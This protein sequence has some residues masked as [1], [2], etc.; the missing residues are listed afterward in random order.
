MC[1]LS[2]GVKQCYPTLSPQGG[3]IGT[4][5]CGEPAQKPALSTPCTW[6]LI[7]HEPVILKCFGCVR[8]EGLRR[9]AAAAV[10][11]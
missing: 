2:A 6:F 4:T 9:M 1:S 11:Y 10:S 5:Q 3:T 7:N 8:S